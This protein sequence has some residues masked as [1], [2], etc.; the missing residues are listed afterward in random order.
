MEIKR[1]GQLIKSVMDYFHIHSC[2]NIIYQTIVT[3]IITKFLIISLLLFHRRQNKN[4]IYCKKKPHCLSRKHS[5]NQ[6]VIDK[7]T[8]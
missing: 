2:I 1:V 7:N 6:L 3:I 5:H 8:Y 4:R